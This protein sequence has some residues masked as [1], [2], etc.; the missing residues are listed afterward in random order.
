MLLCA[1]AAQSSL[2]RRRIQANSCLKQICLSRNIIQRDKQPR[3]LA[4]AGVLLSYWS[5]PKFITDLM[6]YG[7]RARQPWI[8]GGTFALL[9]SGGRNSYYITGLILLMRRGLPPYALLKIQAPLLFR[10]V[11]AQFGRW[12]GALFWVCSPNCTQ[13]YIFPLTHIWFACSLCYRNPDREKSL[14]DWGNWLGLPPTLHPS[15]PLVTLL[16]VPSS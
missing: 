6:T 1:V 13:Q 8:T 5:Q 2:D 3:R 9:D 4:H 11:A 16:A 10:A 7:K 15:R 14:T 12:Q